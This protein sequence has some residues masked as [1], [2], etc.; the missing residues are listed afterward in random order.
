MAVLY[1]LITGTAI[2]ITIL[3]S[4][5][6]QMMV[7]TMDDRTSWSDQDKASNALLCILGFGIGEIVGSIIFGKVTDKSSPR[8]TI[9]VNIVALTVGYGFLVLYGTIYNFDF[10]LGV[11]MTFFWGF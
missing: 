11:L 8:I 2:N 5:F 7:D 1:P 9:L 10:A 3:S 6:V 4:V